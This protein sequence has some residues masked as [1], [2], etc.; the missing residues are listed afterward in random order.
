MRDGR[1][2]ECGQTFRS[3]EPTEEG[4]EVKLRLWR[5][6]S[7]VDWID[8]LLFGRGRYPASS[9]ELVSADAEELLREHGGGGA[10]AV[11][12]ERKSAIDPSRPEGHWLLV[13][14]AIAEHLDLRVGGSGYD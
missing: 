3:D 2:R 7:L 14:R 12:G 1:G 13:R 6:R 9:R 11:A 4:A 8:H 5:P 10:Y